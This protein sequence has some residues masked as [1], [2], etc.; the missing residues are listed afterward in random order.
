M[1]T[2]L[3]CAALLITPTTAATFQL[4]VDS[5]Q[6]IDL[7]DAARPVRISTDAAGA[8][9]ILATTP[10]PPAGAVLLGSGA[11]FPYCVTKF[12][13]G[14]GTVVWTACLD[15]VAS[16]MAVDSGGSAS[17]ASRDV[18]SGNSLLTRL[19]PGGSSIASQAVLGAGLG[20]L[21]VAAAPDGR[22]W[23][24]GQ[25]A[26]GASPSLKTTPDAPQPAAPNNL[27]SHPFVLRVNPA[28]TAIDYATYLTGT[29]G[30]TTLGI[31][32]D[33]TGAAVVAGFTTS[34]DFP[35]TSGP[36]SSTP[37]FLVRLRPGAAR[38]VYVIAT[39]DADYSAGPVAVDPAG[40]ALIAVTATQGLMLRRFDP[41]GA[42]TLSRP[43]PDSLVL[44]VGLDGAG[45]AYILGKGPAN[46]PVRNNLASCGS[47]HL[48][49]LD[50]A[51][52]LLQATW[53]AGA[54]AGRATIA[55]RNDA[56]VYTVT[57]PD[58]ASPFPSFWLLTRL[59]PGGTSDPVLLGC[60][61]DSANF[62]L[63][64]IA[65]GEWLSVFGEGFGPE[66]QVLFDGRPAPLLGVRE[67]EIRTVA[68]WSLE[69][70]KTTSIC[71]A[72]Y[73]VTRPVVEAAPVIFPA[74]D[75]YTFAANQDGTLNSATNPAPAGTFV[76]IFG[77]GFGPVSPTPR[78]GAIIAWPWPVNL[79]PVTAGYT[80]SSPI[81][82]IHFFPLQVTYAGPMPFSVAGL[83]VIRLEATGLFVNLYVGGTVVRIL[84]H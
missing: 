67:G 52:D 13:Q 65:P 58:A 61:G 24:A 82:G 56:T 1:L 12:A 72:G 32:A 35:F 31:A 73:C 51:G 19:S 11:F 47:A 80:F 71:V 63:G 29:F 79:L 53:L 3:A 10:R 76:Y 50:P 74:P 68:P 64:P 55:I 30:A 70:G 7:P 23:L 17:I 43:L 57:S 27:Y 60:V 49:V 5:V 54:P 45:N 69:P 22:I 4:A 9:Y 46:Y 78:D 66:P 48:S 16:D 62:G 34:P 21:A 20:P 25:T 18:S 77:T 26:A 28:G 14:C 42:L 8:V 44:G 41:Q 83:S 40:N 81:S 84:I 39:G 38:P 33:G 2:R 36:H 6:R 59:S 75:G 15:Q 37:S